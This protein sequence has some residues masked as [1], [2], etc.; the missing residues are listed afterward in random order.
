M[1]SRVDVWK[2]KKK[3]TKFQALFSVVMSSDWPQQE[4]FVQVSRVHDGTLFFPS[5]FLSF[6]FFFFFFF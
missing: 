1:E 2:K 6:F 5:V 4:E 3:Q